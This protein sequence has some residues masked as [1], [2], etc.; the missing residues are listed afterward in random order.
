MAELSRKHYS[1]KKDRVKTHSYRLQAQILNLPGCKILWLNTYMP[2]DPQ[3]I[4][5]Y[6]DSVLR[7]V[8]CEVES[9]LSS[10]TYTDVI[11]AGDLN[12]DMSRRTYFS[13]TMASF[14][15]KLG[16]V[17]LWSQHPV[18]YTYMHMDHKSLS[19]ID[20]FMLSPRLL[21][22]VEDCGIVERGDNLSGHC[23]IW[24][25]LRLGALP[26]KKSSSAWVPRKP[27]WS[28]ATQESIA[29]YSHNLESKL[30]AINLPLLEL[31]CQN[32]LCQDQSHSEKR[33]SF[34]LD[35]LMSLVEC[36]THHFLC[37]GDR[38]EYF[39]QY[40]VTP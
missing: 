5:E 8:L 27:A 24:V 30:C 15:E 10:C 26:V 14:V 22:L 13:T 25:R 33:D 23:P 29:D 35:I 11:W 7:E 40:T 9:L 3:R 12:W 32:P 1:V 38:Q 20:H 4:N 37:L 16:L 28:K 31:G 39:G 19:V 6:D 18:K 2:T 36:P 34:V 21:S 17:S